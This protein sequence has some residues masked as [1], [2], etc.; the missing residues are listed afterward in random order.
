MTN[1]AV[2]QAVTDV[3]EDLRPVDFQKFIFQLR[4]RRKD[5]RFTPNDVDNKSAVGVAD[6]L[7]IK[8]TEPEA[9]QVALD[10]L[11]LIN[12]KSQAERLGE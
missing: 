9:L 5:P 3:L 7:F 10:I 6:V 12:C 11:R 8:F 2:I 1:K 4:D